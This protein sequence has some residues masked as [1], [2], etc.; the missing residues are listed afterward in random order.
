MND[1]ADFISILWGFHCE[2]VITIREALQEAHQQGILVLASASNSGANDPITLPAN[3]PIME[4]S[5]RS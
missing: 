3:I 4:P 1:Q 2:G 5:S